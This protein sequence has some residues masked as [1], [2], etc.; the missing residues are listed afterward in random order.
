MPSLQEPLLQCAQHAHCLCCCRIPPDSCLAA[1]FRHAHASMATHC[2]TTTLL[3]AAFAGALA[4]AEAPRCCL[5]T[6]Q[7]HTHPATL[8]SH[9]ATQLPGTLNTHTTVKPALLFTSCICSRHPARHLSNYHTKRPL[10][11]GR[12]PACLKESNP[13]AGKRLV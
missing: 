7:P 3:M 10:L 2:C 11:A 8:S 12:L 13:I 9:R 1:S 5:V 6:H 4:P